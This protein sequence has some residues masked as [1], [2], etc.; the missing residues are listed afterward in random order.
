MQWLDS[1]LERILPPAREIKNKKIKA[2]DEGKKERR[3]S[4]G[5]TTPTLLYVPG[6]VPLRL[7]YRGRFCQHMLLHASR[8]CR[9]IIHCFLVSFLLGNN[10]YISLLVWKST[11]A[12][13]STI[14]IDSHC[15][16]IPLHN[17][18]GC[19]RRPS[20]R[21]FTR[22]WPWFSLQVILGKK[23]KK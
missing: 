11:E 16:C 17:T 13:F 19:F 8:S 7:L 15:R 10:E 2:K 6:W 23:K 3:A 22:W 14:W 9:E 21:S 5:W 4:Q 1:G 12:S 18:H 20:P